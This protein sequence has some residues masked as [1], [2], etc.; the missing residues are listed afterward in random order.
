MATQ[1]R[2][3]FVRDTLEG[4]RMNADIAATIE[5]GVFVRRATVVG[6]EVFQKATTTAHGTT[7]LGVSQVRT[8][9]PKGEPGGPEEPSIR[10]GL[11]KLIGLY[12]MSGRA[13]ETY[14]AFDY[15][16]IDGT[17]ADGQSVRLYDPGGGD[18][19]D[20]IVGIV[21]P[22][23]AIGGVAGSAFNIPVWIAPRGLGRNNGVDSLVLV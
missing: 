1:D 2:A 18:T 21:W 3:A 10:S 9:L 5:S 6:E 13:A 14:Q 4:V 23:M 15:L 11:I 19:F 20:Q 22:G 7:L 16:V 8:P 12:S 17:P